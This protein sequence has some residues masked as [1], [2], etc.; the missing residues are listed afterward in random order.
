MA[1]TTE[2]RYRRLYLSL[3]DELDNKEKEWEALDLRLRRVLAHLL[4]IAE[5]PST[6]ELSAELAQIRES[7]RNGLELGA[8]EER[9]EVLRDRILRETRWVEDDPGFPPL[10]Q[11]LI[12]LVER[13]P[14]PPDMSEEAVAVIEALEAG[15][16]PDGL[17]DAIEQITH[18]V[19]QVRAKVQEEKRELEALLQEVT[20]RLRGIDQDLAA[21]LSHACDGFSKTRS[22]DE[23]VRAE[24]QDLESSSRDAADLD[25]LKGA[26]RGAL[27]AI[28]AHLETLQ[29]HETEQ[30]E[31]L[32]SEVERLR[33]T[34]HQLESEVEEY[35]EQTRRARELSLRDPL[36]GVHNRLAYQERAEEEQ[37]RWQRYGAPLSV[38]V[39]DLDHFKRINDNHGHRAGDLVLK[40]TAQLARSQMR[41]VDFFARYGGEEFV[42]LLPE[43]PLEAARVVAEKVRAAVEG[44]RFHSRGKRV[45]VTVSCGV[46]QLR[47]GDTVATAFQRADK[48]LY[49]AKERGR[50]RTVTET[51]L[52]APAAG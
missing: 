20:A 31:R 51:E 35:R 18:L 3:V 16:P 46:A 36:T 43:T 42:A 12:H 41:Q 38:I 6:P 11:I 1:E 39:F 10:H 25:A 52:P 32:K 14:L 45:D 23:A 15:I 21:A 26:V 44:F 37:A 22:F 19:Y 48:A 28:R 50:N 29:Q 7:L 2:Q 24:I 17:P 33:A 40:T 9:L 49:G 5:G 27:D 13:L 34:V 4:V 47:E 30:E 8:I